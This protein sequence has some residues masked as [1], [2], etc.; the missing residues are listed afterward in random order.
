MIAAIKRKLA[1]LRAEG[2]DKL[3]TPH[4]RRAVFVLRY[5]D[6]LIGYLALEHGQWR[7]AYAPSF[8]RQSEIRPIVDFPDLNRVYHSDRLWPFFEHRIPSAAQPQIRRMMED[9]G[10]DERDAVQLLTKFGRRSITNPLAL[11]P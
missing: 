1:Q 11:S 10:L 6:E 4:D 8:Q 7:F 2:H 5:D 3:E 9:A